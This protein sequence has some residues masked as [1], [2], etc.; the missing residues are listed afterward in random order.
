VNNSHRRLE[1]AY[2]GMRI[3]LFGGSFNPAH[4]GHAHVAETAMRRLGLDKVWWLVT[5]QN[6]LKNAR[7]TAPLAE[8]MKSAR[9]FAHGPAMIVTDIESRLGTRFSI[10]L[11]L[12]LRRRHPGVRFVWV[13][14]SDNLN[15]FHRWRRWADIVHLAPIAFVARPGALAKARLSPFARRFALNRWTGAAS[16]LADRHPPAWIVLTNPLDSASS[17]ALRARRARKVT[18]NSEN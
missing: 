9:A 1:P 2:R 14:G 7:E 4:E 15:N 5:P 11:L 17:T 10:D 3:G 13:M 6:P 12:K 18:T 16:T 8:R